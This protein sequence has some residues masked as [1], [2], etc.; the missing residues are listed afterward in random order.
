MYASMLKIPAI[1]IIISLLI[2]FAL[3]R[4]MDVIML[5]GLDELDDPLWDRKK[6]ERTFEE[7]EDTTVISSI[8]LNNLE[9]VAEKKEKAVFLYASAFGG[10][11]DWELETVGEYYDLVYNGI[12][13]IPGG[14]IVEYWKCNLKEMS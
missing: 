7:N 9:E 8:S 6:A 11:R 3:T 4:R 10:D 13:Y 5:G 2:A 12:V 1:I 14:G